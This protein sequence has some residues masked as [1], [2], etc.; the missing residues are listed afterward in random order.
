MVWDV[1]GRRW[2]GVAQFGETERRQRKQACEDKLKGSVGCRRVGLWNH[3]A[4][5]G[6]WRAT[7]QD[8]GEEANG[9]QHGNSLSGC[10]RGTEFV[11][12]QDA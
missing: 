3:R 4:A 12:S 9:I 7:R 11:N 2:D 1:R 8:R 6:S 10:R 5:S